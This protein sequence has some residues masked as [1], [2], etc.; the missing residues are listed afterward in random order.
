M[1]ACALVLGSILLSGQGRPA[2]MP[3]FNGHNLDGW[4][5]KITGYDFGDNFANTFRVENGVI[6]VSYDGYGGLFKG[7]FGHL[8]YKTPY[9]NY[10]MRLEYRFTGKQMPDGPGWA[11]ENSG[12]MIHCQDP[13]TMRKDQDF[14]VSCEVQLLGG[15]VDGER[16]TGNCCTPGTNIVIGG[17]LI[18]QHTNN[19]NSATYRGDQWVKILIE[20][21]GS[22]KVVHTV[23]GKEVLT[24]SGIQYDPTDPDAK[25]LIKDG[26][27]LID[28]GYIS[29][30]SESHPCEFRNIE[31]LK[32]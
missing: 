18:T 11:F 21:R 25:P 13:K 26:K 20:V 14:P 27:L 3:M 16:P 32:L 19:S 8:F 31:I 23:N 10:M 6:K 24:Y 29:L 2:W 15:D 5:P 30:Q 28:G 9:S 7:R 4:T 1:L 22:G 17:K 12:I